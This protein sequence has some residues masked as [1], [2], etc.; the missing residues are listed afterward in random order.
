MPQFAIDFGITKKTR[1]EPFG[2]GAEGS[3]TIKGEFQQAEFLRGL[4]E[5][6]EL[7]LEA[8][9]GADHFCIGALE[10]GALVYR[11]ATHVAKAFRKELDLQK[12]D[13]TKMLVWA[14]QQR[15]EAFRIYTREE[16]PYERLK[17]IV[18]E[19]LSYQRHFRKVVEARLI[20]FARGR[21]LMTR[22]DEVFLRVLRE[23]K[24]NNPVLSSCVS[25]E[26]RLHKEVVEAL[27]ALPL[28]REVFARIPRFP[29][30]AAAL[31]IAEVGDPDQYHSLAHLRRRVGFAVFDGEASV[32][33]RSKGTRLDYDPDALIGYW[34]AVQFGVVMSKPED[35]NPWRELFDLRKAY[36][37][38]KGRAVTSNPRR[39]G[40]RRY[41]RGHL[42]QMAMR[43]VGEKLLRAI[44][45]Y[46]RSYKRGEELPEAIVPTFEAPWINDEIRRLAAQILEE[47][48]ERKKSKKGS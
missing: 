19:Y 6:D 33:R 26:R 23:E 5:G 9:S 22:S 48:R 45:K 32:S 38:S 17:V 24:A 2:N 15:P 41:T 37:I 8:G 1:V 40:L 11:L 34:Y 30:V 4:S 28:Y 31:I 47:A 7:Y 35:E 12:K 13:T 43:Y 42:N 29:K 10:Q 21:Y 44:W 18:R 25:E 16:L 3:F 36:E 39:P 14:A 20:G 46:W 27:E